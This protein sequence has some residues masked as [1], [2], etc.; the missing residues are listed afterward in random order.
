MVGHIAPG[1]PLHAERLGHIVLAAHET[2]GDKG[3][4]AVVGELFAGGYHAG[5]AG[6]GVTLG[7]EIGDDRAGQVAG[8]VLQKLFDG[9]LVDAGVFAELGKTLGLAVVHLQNLGPLGPG[10]IRGPFFRGLGHHFQCHEVGAALPQGGTLTVVAGVAAADDEDIPACRVDGPAVGKLAV[11]QTPGHAGEVVYREVN[12]L[13]VAARDV[14]IAGFLG[15][16]AE[17]DGVIA[18]QD[19]SGIHSPTHIHIGA[20]LDAFGLHDLDAALDDGFVQLH[21]GDAVHQQTAHT[22][23][24]LEDGDGMTPDVEVFGHRQARRAAADDG[25]AL[26]GA[27]RRRGGMEPALGVARLHDGV[28]VLPDSDAAAGDVAAGAGGLT[29]G[30]AD[31]AR[32]LRETVGGAQAAEGQLPFALIDQIVPLGDEVVQRAAGGHHRKP[33]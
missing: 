19:L 10:I 22:V 9:G 30:R 15:T 11:Q 6:V 4:L 3:Q 5:A 16:A 12:S 23:S 31:P 20:E 1:V 25:H 7:L 17:H 8:V 32:E 24:T 27:G 26:A 14:Q 2:G 13:R 33:L 21:V 28:F 29:Q 18:V